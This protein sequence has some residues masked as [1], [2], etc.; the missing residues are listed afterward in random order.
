MDYYDCIFYG[1]FYCRLNG[2]FNLPDTSV[3][4]RFMISLFP[5]LY[6]LQHLHQEYEGKETLWEHQYRIGKS[7][8]FSLEKSTI[9]I[10]KLK[11]SYYNNLLGNFFQTSRVMGL[12]TI[13]YVRNSDAKK[14]FQPLEK[15][16]H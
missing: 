3:L 1:K 5:W 8:L 12:I 16:F 15:Y 13:L 10:Q 6:F 2:R 14:D 7:S 11:F 4:I 9:F